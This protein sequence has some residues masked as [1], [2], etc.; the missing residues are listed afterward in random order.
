M[1]DKKVFWKEFLKATIVVLCVAL[2]ICITW[3]IPQLASW[4]D[5]NFPSIPLDDHIPLITQ[6]VWVYYFT[7]PLGIA[8]IY[9]LY[10]KNREAM[11]NVVTAFVLACFISMIFYFVYPTEMI[12]PALD[13]VTLADKMTIATW[14]ASRPVCCLPSQHCFMALSCIFASF[15]EK[16]THWAIR[17][18]TIICGVLIIM[19][20]V[21]IKQHYFLDF[22][23]SLVI[24]TPIFLTC[25]FSKWGTSVH[26]FICNKTTKKSEN[27]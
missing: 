7:F 21:F 22:I 3:G 4:G 16:K 11:W 2:T 27:E 23:A 19:S 14:H 12:K 8:S 24:I 20:T 17:V 10:F 9:I 26:S 6:F 18:F 1:M 15:F 13:P 5:P 25:L